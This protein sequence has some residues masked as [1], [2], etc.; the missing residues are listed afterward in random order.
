MDYGLLGLPPNLLHVLVNKPGLS[1][2]A[3]ISDNL[4]FAILSLVSALVCANLS[5][6]CNSLVVFFMF[7]IETADAIPKAR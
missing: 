3:L 4:A 5:L 6:S 1:L 7:H 2:L